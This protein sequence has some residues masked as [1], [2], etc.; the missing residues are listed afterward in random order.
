M[1]SVMELRRHHILEQS[2]RRFRGMY[3]ECQAIGKKLLS[4][5]IGIEQEPDEGNPEGE[6]SL[7]NIYLQIDEVTKVL[8]RMIK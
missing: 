2:L 4:V 5:G 7:S 1:N 8:E 6:F 3:Y